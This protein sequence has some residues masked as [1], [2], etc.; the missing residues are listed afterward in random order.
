VPNIL[1]IEDSDLNRDLIS[2]YLGLF[3]YAVT[4]AT[5]GAA[6][7][8]VAQSQGQNFDLILMD[9][10]LPEVDGW[11][12]TRRLKADAATKSLPVI[13]LTAHAMVGDREKALEA[14]CDD[15]ATKPI[16]FNTL[17]GKIEELCNK[18]STI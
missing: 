18:A 12:V 4:S 17:I 14:G 1:L 6:G 15:Y 13:A 3:G 16:D 2:R 9:M 11:E 5:N 7:L 10:N 8:H